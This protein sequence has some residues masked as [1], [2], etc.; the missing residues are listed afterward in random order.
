MDNKI[1]KERF[2]QK[3][4][5]IHGN[6][7]DYSKPVRL[8]RVMDRFPELKVVGAHFGGYQCWEDSLMYLCGRRNLW[9]DTSSSLQFMDI[10]LA[11]KIIR[12]QGVDRILF[13]TDYPITDQNEELKQIARLGLNEEEQKAVLYENAARLLGLDE[14]C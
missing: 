5:K 4:K 12:A 2:V 9:M 11:K 7:Y 10:E 6:R 3:A 1:Q 13:G 14:I 8:A